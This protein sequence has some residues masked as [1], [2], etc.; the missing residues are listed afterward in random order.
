[1]KKMRIWE[2]FY[3]RWNADLMS[4]ADESVEHT[5]REAVIRLLKENRNLKYLLSKERDI[6]DLKRNS[7]LSQSTPSVPSLAQ[8]TN[9]P[10][11]AN[12]VTT[13]T[14]SQTPVP[15]RVPRKKK[16]KDKKRKSLPPVPSN[17]TASPSPP[18]KRQPPASSSKKRESPHTRVKSDQ[19]GGTAW[20]R[21]KMEPGKKRKWGI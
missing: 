12:T 20:A 14:L 5:L 16:E 8:S 3:F 18:Q 15:P 21:A 4:T 9:I 2:R 17:T 19:T 11:R 13:N 7:P 1:M 6:I 10:P